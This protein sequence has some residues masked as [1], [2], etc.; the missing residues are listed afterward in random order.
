MKFTE[1]IMR[2]RSTIQSKP[3]I[4]ARSTGFI[5]RR[6]LLFTILISGI[7]GSLSSFAAVPPYLLISDWSAEVITEF[8]A[9]GSPVGNWA[10][11][12]G[13]FNPSYIIFGPDGNLYSSYGG[14]NRVHRFA[15]DG[16]DLGAFAT[17][18]LDFP[19]DLT[20][21]SAGNLYVA[22]FPGSRAGGAGT[23]SR[24]SPSGTFIDV[25]ISGLTTPRGIV[26][27]SAGNMWVA[28]RAA[29][30]IRKFGP[31]GEN[32][33]ISSTTS[34]SGPLGL[35]VDCSDNLYVSNEFGNTI[36]RFDS[37]GTH[38]GR[39]GTVPGGSNSANLRFGPDGNLYL[40][41][42]TNN[43]YSWL[44]DGTPLGVF[45]NS[46]AFGGRPTG[47]AFSDGGQGCGS[48]DSDGDGIPDDDDM[49]PG[50]DDNV[51]TDGDLVPDYCDPC[52]LDFDNDADDD[53]VCGN[54]DVC[55]GGNDEDDADGDLTPDFCDVC[56]ADPFN[57]ADNDGLCLDDDNCP[58][59]SNSY[60]SDLDKD[61][62]GDACDPD[63]DGDGFLN[64]EDNCEYDVNPDQLDFDNDGEGDVC[65]TDS[66]GDGVV[67]AGDACVPTPLDEVVDADGCS[68]AG[69][70]ACENNWKNHGAYVRCVAHTSED[71]ADAGLISEAEKD[72][73]VSAA[74]QSGCGHRN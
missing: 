73:I 19:Q 16:T 27:D 28:E 47:I 39:F 54:V 33:G 74:G 23:V 29:N 55:P 18:N 7:F 59:V 58:T 41:N 65:D 11:S 8:D 53:G 3:V 37:S 60:Q 20:F 1:Q 36:E 66:D 42:A 70:C 56:P 72:A 4:L 67:D 34:L 30:R 5:S 62:V 63:I 69:L 57:D 13:D 2:T 46:L 10:N 44:P 24:F 31:N 14:A 49:C 51:D 12:G 43:V 64:G 6:V 45:A 25:F 35:V 15:P 61:D 50:G 26:I 32:L 21:D 22:N 40:A 9:S 71:F 52:P 17:T 68:I 48:P 38:L